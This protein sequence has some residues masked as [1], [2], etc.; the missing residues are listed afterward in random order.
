MVVSWRTLQAAVRWNKLSAVVTYGVNDSPGPLSTAGLTSG[1]LYGLGIATVDG[2]PF[3]AYSPPCNPPGC[4][5]GSYLFDPA[6]QPPTFPY[7][8]YQTGLFVCCVNF[9]SAWTQHSG[10][11][12]LRYGFS[13]NVSAEVFYAGENSLMLL[14]N[15]TRY[16]ISCLP[17]AT[18]VQP[19][20]HSSVSIPLR[21]RGAGCFEFAR[22]KNHCPTGARHLASRGLAKS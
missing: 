1:N 6:I 17:P 22:G 8:G 19:E 15:R 21:S 7:Y 18:L 3:T 16:L 5:Y 11:V 14:Q 13:P 12:A 20:C 9:S 10:S 2:H 4:Q